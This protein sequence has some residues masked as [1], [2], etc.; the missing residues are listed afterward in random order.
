MTEVIPQTPQGT[1]D[2]PPV[3]TIPA[4]GDAPTPTPQGNEAPPAAPVEITPNE[5][6]PPVPAPAPT[7]VVPTPVD[8][9]KKFGESTRENQIVTS[10]LSELQKVLGDITRQEVP[11]EDEMKRI[12]PEWEYLTDREKAREMKIVVL[13]RRQNHIIKTF[14]DITTDV[15]NVRKLGEYIESKSELK[16]KE[17]AF[18]AFASKDS[19]KG[20]AMETLLAAFLYEVRDDTPAPVTPPA[21]DTPPSLERSRPSGGTP[22]PPANRGR[23]D[24]EL[25][26]LRT[27]DPKR[28]NELIRTGQI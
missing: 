21:D 15:D 9:K 27:K 10:R 16:G 28:Y 6:V 26:E 20:V 25:K 13:E 11:T 24:E 7:P 23:S 22:P 12:E 5:V 8:Y 1:Q 4:T 18:R 17:D 2:T 19:N 3:V 14:S